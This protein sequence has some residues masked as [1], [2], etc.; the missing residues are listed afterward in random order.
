[1]I[2]IRK[3]VYNQL[4]AVH[5]RVYFL[6]APETAVFPYLVYEMEI[7]DLGDR[8][9]LLTVD[10]DGWSHD[11]DTTDLEN[12]MSNTKNR[13]DRAIIV[14]EKLVVNFYLDRQLALTD[15]DPSIHRRKYIYQGR[16]FER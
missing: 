1:M 3:A 10:V 13:F 4:K 14:N 6:R 12:I 16:L 2:E 9:K 11:P 5:P 7:T 8:L 15:E